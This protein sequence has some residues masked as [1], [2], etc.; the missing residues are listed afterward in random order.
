MGVPG[1]SGKK[2]RRNKRQNPSALANRTPPKKDI[3]SALRGQRQLQQRRISFVPAKRPQNGDI[4]A[5]AGANG[6]M[7]Q[8][9]K[10]DAGASGKKGGR[11]EEEQFEEVAQPLYPRVRIRRVLEWKR[12]NKIGP[13]LHNLG[14]TCFCNAVLQCLTYTPPLANFCLEQSHSARLSNKTDNSGKYDAMA[15]MERHVATALS[16]EKG[17]IRPTTIVNNLK[18]IGPRLKVGRQEDAHEFNRLLIECMHVADLGA[19]NF[20][21]SPYSR[22]AQTGVLHGIFG[23]HL[24][25]QVPS[26]MVLDVPES[27]CISIYRVGFSHGHIHLPSSRRTDVCVLS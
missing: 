25:S 9:V 7:P 15:A 2:Q 26:F 3:D 14:N 6:T 18:K 1:S 22:P 13:G 5:T 4:I 17:A 12:V 21:A 27:P 20:T 10:K 23:G 8:H 16:T 11:M 19:Y 24:R